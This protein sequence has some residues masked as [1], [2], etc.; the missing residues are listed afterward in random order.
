MGPA[1]CIIVIHDSIQVEASITNHLRDP[2]L[3]LEKYKAVQV[4]L[5][6]ED[7]NQQ[8]CKFSGNFIPYIEIIMKF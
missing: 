5:M 4:F 6:Y 7:R 2:M 3:Y 1:S 8:D